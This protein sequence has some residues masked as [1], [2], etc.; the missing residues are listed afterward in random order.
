MDQGPVGKFSGLLGAG[1]PVALLDV[2]R[3]VPF[4]PGRPLE[5]QGTAILLI[6]AC[7]G[8]EPGDPLLPGLPVPFPVCP[9]SLR[10][11]LDGVEA[12]RPD[13]LDGPVRVPGV[14]P[15]DHLAHPTDRERDVAA[16]HD[17]APAALDRLAD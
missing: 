12:E 4:P 7:V 13:V 1:V 11:V 10:L 15:L 6:P 14:G 17:A 3:H 8:D 5:G 9:A 16:A 2:D